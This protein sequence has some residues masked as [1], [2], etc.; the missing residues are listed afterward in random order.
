M[1]GAHRGSISCGGWSGGGSVLALAS[2]N[3]L[4]ISAPLLNASWE[5]TAAKVALPNNDVHFHEL[6]FSPSGSALAALAGTSI[7]RH[8]AIFTFAPAEPGSSGRSPPPARG[9]RKSLTRQL[10]QKMTDV[11]HAAADRVQELAS[12]SS[13]SNEGPKLTMVTVGEMRPNAKLGG[14]VA[15]VWLQGHTWCTPT[16]RTFPSVR[17]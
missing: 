10:S 17:S 6:V 14:I 15:M 12:P 5:H 7:F 9:G 4:K 13:S 3:Q 2:L 11:A 8:L 1:A 16:P